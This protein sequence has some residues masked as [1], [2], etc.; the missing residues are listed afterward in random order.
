[1]LDLSYNGMTDEV[2]RLL[3]K[4]LRVQGDKRDQHLWMASLRKKAAVNRE[5]ICLREIYLKYNKLEDV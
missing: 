5:T 1:M 4:L 2:G 3:E